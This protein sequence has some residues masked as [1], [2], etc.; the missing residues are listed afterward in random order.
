[1]SN[2]KEQTVVEASITEYN[3]SAYVSL[4]YDALREILEA[5]C[6]LHGY[7]VLSHVC[8]G[9]LLNEYLEDFDYHGF[10]K[11]RWVRNSINYYG[12]KVPY[13]Q[14]KQAIQQIF[15]LKK[16]IAETYFDQT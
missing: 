3:I 2:I 6:M 11:L 14:G 4:A 5:L 16:S 9:E 8:V 15:T 7:K 12:E 13:D 1:M 10:N